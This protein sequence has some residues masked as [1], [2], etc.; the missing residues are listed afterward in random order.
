MLWSNVLLVRGNY[1]RLHLI[2]SHDL[3]DLLPAAV[4]VHVE[5]TYRLF[6]KRAVFCGTS[7]ADEALL[8]FLTPW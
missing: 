1:F 4:P 5:R 7:I 2:D 8:G 6:A 3:V